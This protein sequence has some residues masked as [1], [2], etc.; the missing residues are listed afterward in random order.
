M[1]VSAATVVVIWATRGDLA[2]QNQHSLGK[3]RANDPFVSHD[4]V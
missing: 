1:R 2:Q 4:V 3:T